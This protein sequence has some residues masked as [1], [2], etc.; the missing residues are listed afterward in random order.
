MNQNFLTLLLDEDVLRKIKKRFFLSIIAKYYY[1]YIR[2]NY[3]Y[4][5]NN[6]ADKQIGDY[7]E[8]SYLNTSFIIHKIIQENLEFP[9]GLCSHY[10][11][12]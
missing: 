7:H 6:N 1:T 11:P 4:F 10:N 5:V 8:I 3:L 2:H 9:H 12:A